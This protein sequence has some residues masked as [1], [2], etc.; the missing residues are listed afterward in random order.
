MTQD[1]VSEQTLLEL[2]KKF[3]DLT[4]ELAFNNAISTTQTP[5]P[6]VLRLRSAFTAINIDAKGF[7]PQDIVPIRLLIKGVELADGLEDY[8]VTVFHELELLDTQTKE[9]LVKAIRKGNTLKL[10]NRQENLSSNHFD[11]LLEQWGLDIIEGFEQFSFVFNKNT[12]KN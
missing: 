11:L 2:G 4:K 12:E 7:K 1:K 5:G 6:G 3:N 8:H 9:V 10:R